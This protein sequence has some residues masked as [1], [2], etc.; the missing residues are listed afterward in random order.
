MIYLILLCIEANSLL[1]FQ[2]RIFPENAAY[3][4]RILLFMVENRGDLF[5]RANLID[6]SGL[7]KKK[8]FISSL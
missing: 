6:I 4:N 7:G 5:L 2:E 1:P 8:S 3:L